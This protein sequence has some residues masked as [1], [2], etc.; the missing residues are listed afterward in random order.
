MQGANFFSILC[1]G[2]TDAS[3]KDQECFYVLWFDPQP[4]EKGK[5]DKVAVN[6]SFLGIQNTKARDGGSTAE[7]I[8]LGID[9]C[10]EE[11]GIEEYDI[12]LI[13]FGADG[14]NVNKGD[15]TGLKSLL[16]EKALWLLF[17]WCHFPRVKKIILL[18]TKKKTNFFAAFAVLGQINEI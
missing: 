2:A 13:G 8:K 14:V 1:D 10:F 6:L 15:K 11:L 7:G 4:M 5:R 16:R 9:R 3:T 18:T 12:K 17:I